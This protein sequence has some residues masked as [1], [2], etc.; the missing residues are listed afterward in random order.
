MAMT[1]TIA[2]LIA[3]DACTIKNADCVKVSFPDFYE[4]L[5]EVTFD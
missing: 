4:K 2:S 1:F 5:R 3:N